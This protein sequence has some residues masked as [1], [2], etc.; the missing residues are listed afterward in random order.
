MD[1][2]KVDDIV[3]MLDNLMGKEGGHVNVKVD[4]GTDTLEKKVQTN[5]SLEC[6]GNMACSVPTMHIG[7][8]DED[9]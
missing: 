7:I 3:A 9:N 2:S 4:D 6:A 1:N 5:N 8:D